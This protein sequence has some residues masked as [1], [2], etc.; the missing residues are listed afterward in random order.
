MLKDLILKNRS[1]RR[2]DQSVTV[3]MELLREMVD[4]ARLSGSARNMQPLKYMLFND[5]S[6]CA[7]IFP[8]L[9]WGGTN[10]WD[11]T[12]LLSTLHAV[13]AV[14]DGGAATAIGQWSLV[15]IMHLAATAACFGISVWYFQKR[16][17]RDA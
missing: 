15:M 17:L 10:F 2:F 8:A 5:P 7:R 11:Y 12:P 6:E 1:Y 4:A 13:D 14:S 9:A 16:Y 3:P